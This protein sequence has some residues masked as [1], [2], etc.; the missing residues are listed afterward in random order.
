MSTDGHIKSKWLKVMVV[1]LK[2]DI[3]QVGDYFPEYETEINNTMREAWRSGVS[4][5]W[6]CEKR[7]GMSTKE[8]RIIKEE[9]VLAIESWLNK[10]STTK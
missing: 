7:H 3:K 1:A 9:G 6:Y 10:V 2:L 5:Y 4:I 8:Y